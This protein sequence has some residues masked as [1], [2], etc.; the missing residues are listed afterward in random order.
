MDGLSFGAVASAYGFLRSVVADL[1]CVRRAHGADPRVGRWCQLVQSY[2]LNP[3]TALLYLGVADAPI[4]IASDNSLLASHLNAKLLGQSAE[5]FG[6]R[7]D[8]LLASDNRIYDCVHLESSLKG[9]VGDL[10]AWKSTGED[11]ALL[12]F[13]SGSWELE[14]SIS[15]AGA[16]VLERTNGG[17]GE[18]T[19]PLYRPVSS[20]QWWANDKQR[21]LSLSAIWTAWHMGFEVRGYRLPEK[22]CRA[23]AE[24]IA[25]PGPVVARQGRG[26]WHPDDYV[27]RPS[28]VAKGGSWIDSVA[29][30]HADELESLVREAGG[31]LREWKRRHKQAAYAE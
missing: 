22:K 8:W 12:A 29:N 2:S 15:Q 24:G 10:M 18:R 4:G 25:F 31:Q 17:I 20:L 9:I 26:C 7:L 6:V 30:V 27:V 1:S 14:D 3:L 21:W 5:R 16:L 11:H 23:I 13:K 19:I 28:A